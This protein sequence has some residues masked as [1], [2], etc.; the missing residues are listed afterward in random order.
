VPRAYIGIMQTTPKKDTDMK[1]GSL[2]MLALTLA[3]APGIAGAKQA[4]TP[5]KKP[6]EKHHVARTTQ[7]EHIACTKYGC[8]PV[9]ANCI[10]HTQLN[11]WG[12]PTGYDAIACR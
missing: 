7:P 2:T 8:Y 12:N 1:L 9:P 5:A 11:W 10:P 6:V 4:N 3:L